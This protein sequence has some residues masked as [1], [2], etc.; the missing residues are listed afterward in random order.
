LKAAHTGP[1]KFKQCRQT[2][3]R[4]YGWSRSAFSSPSPPIGSSRLALSA[5]ISRVRSTLRAEKRQVRYLLIAEEQAATRRREQAGGAHRLSY[6]HFALGV[7]S[8]GVGEHVDVQYCSIPSPKLLWKQ[9]CYRFGPICNESVLRGAVEGQAGRPSLQRT[10]NK[11][12]SEFQASP[13]LTQFLLQS[14]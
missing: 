5:G 11:S 10:L 8:A 4:R 6:L 1:S 7:E 3:L 13:S 12:S 2:L 9:D 14:R